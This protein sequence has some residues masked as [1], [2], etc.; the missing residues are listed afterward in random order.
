MHQ[1]S[2]SA[3]KGIER[4]LM[5]QLG[6]FSDCDALCYITVNTMMQQ[7][8][9]E[10]ALEKS[11]R[12]QLLPWAGVKPGLGVDPMSND[13]LKSVLTSSKWSPEVKGI[14]KVLCA[15]GKY[16]PQ[17]KVVGKEGLLPGFK[18]APWKFSRYLF[19]QYDLQTDTLRLA[20]KL[21]TMAIVS[22]WLVNHKQVSDLPV[23]D[24]AVFSEVLKARDRF[25]PAD[26]GRP[27]IF[28]RQRDKAIR[29]PHGGE[30]KYTGQ[31][32]ASHYYADGLEALDVKWL[33]D[34]RNMAY[35]KENSFKGRVARQAILPEHLKE[36]FMGFEW[37]PNRE[38]I[39][40][41]RKKL[42]NGK[43]V[44]KETDGR[45]LPGFEKSGSMLV[46]ANDAVLDIDP[47]RI[48]PKIQIPLGE[49]PG[50]LQLAHAEWVSGI[51]A[52]IGV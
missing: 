22:P 39:P 33:R 43:Q 30:K 3:V 7:N 29:L 6:S 15:K 27:N 19:L 37:L 50:D 11:V 10:V 35:M 51:G 14:I 24:Q 34:P 2:K 17:L 12:E 9:N 45:L 25:F 38:S 23:E 52:G 16:T 5:V 18:E 46:S 1:E 26:D 21:G 20:N 41:Q 47:E 31:L 13:K 48:T 36:C 49:I 40:L 8:T 32:G 28:S 44:V 4:A 42:E